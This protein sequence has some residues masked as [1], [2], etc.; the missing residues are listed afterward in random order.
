[1]R[2]TLKKKQYH[3]QNYRALLRNLIFKKMPHTPFHRV[4]E[5]G[6]KV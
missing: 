4:K 3:I 2:L 6:A 1:M 5:G